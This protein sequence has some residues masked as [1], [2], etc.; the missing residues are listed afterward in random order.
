MNVYSVHDNKAGYYMNPTVAR[1]N[2]EAMR[3]FSDA[4]KHPESLFNK[5]PKDFTLVRIGKWDDEKGVIIP[6]E[7]DILANGADFE[8]NQVS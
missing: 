1:S 6:D 7:P 4:V 3:S 8:E 2:P 5:H